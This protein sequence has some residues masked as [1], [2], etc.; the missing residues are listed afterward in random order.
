MSKDFKHLKPAVDR[1]IN[2]GI[3]DNWLRGV[4]GMVPE[5]SAK[6]Q[7]STQEQEIEGMDVVF[8]DANTHTLSYGSHELI[9]EA[10]IE[11]MVGFAQLVKA[12]SQN[13]VRLD[14]ANAGQGNLVV[15]F[16][17]EEPFTKSEVF[18]AKFTNVLPGVF[19]MKK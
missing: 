5:S 18:G 10:D 13:N 11:K 17:P 6:K 4:C 9:K 7:P 14:F 2:L 3:I 19:G 12:C 16:T 8:L 15:D 1:T